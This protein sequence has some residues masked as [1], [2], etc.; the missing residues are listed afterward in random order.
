MIYGK[1][2]IY[3]II[4]HTSFLS[5]SQYTHVLTH[6]GPLALLF[7]HSVP[8]STSQVAKMYTFTYYHT[9][10]KV[11]LLQQQC[12]LNGSAESQEVGHTS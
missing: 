1:C 3:F 8:N 11:L 6:S 10:K 9:V 2:F 4:L 5:E 12:M 7:Q